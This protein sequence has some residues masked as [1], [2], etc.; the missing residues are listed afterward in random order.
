MG[1]DDRLGG[2]EIA[3]MD[4]EFDLALGREDGGKWEPWL[5]HLTPDEATSSKARTPFRTSIASSMKSF[6][7][8]E[9]RSEKHEDND[10]GLDKK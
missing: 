8:R 7:L 10:T 5:R 2:R 6:P 4:N 1:E 9:T 3:E